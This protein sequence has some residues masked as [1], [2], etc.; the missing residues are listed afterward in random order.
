MRRCAVVLCALFCSLEHISH[1]S[2]HPIVFLGG[3][4]CCALKS[5]DPIDQQG[6]ASKF[7]AEVTHDA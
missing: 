2:W 7:A 1:K 3:I 6:Q 4:G 5:K